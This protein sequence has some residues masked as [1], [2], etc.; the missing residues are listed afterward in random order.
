MSS[1]LFL[2][3]D[4]KQGKNTSSDQSFCANFAARFSSVY[5]SH[6]SQSRRGEPSSMSSKC[7]DKTCHASDPR[8]FD[9][10]GEHFSVKAMMTYRETSENF[11]M[12]L[13]DNLT[14]KCLC[15]SPQGPS[16]NALD[17]QIYKLIPL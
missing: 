11:G 7:R 15:V 8:A 10:S 16:N 9:E 5:A 17:L 2:S 13:V 14:W 3:F 1:S 4:L 6:I 12:I